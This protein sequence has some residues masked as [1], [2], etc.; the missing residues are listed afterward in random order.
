MKRIPALYCSL[1]LA[2][3]ALAQGPTQEARALIGTWRLVES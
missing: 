3:V 1:L 2:S